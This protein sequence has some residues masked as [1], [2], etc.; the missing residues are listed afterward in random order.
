MC[1]ILIQF[2]HNFNRSHEIVFSLHAYRTRQEAER[3]Q[4]QIENLQSQFIHL[5]AQ[6]KKVADGNAQRKELFDN[7]RPSY[8]TGQKSLLDDDD[9]DEP[10][11][12]F[13]GHAFNSQVPSVEDLRKQQTRIIED[14]NE[15]LD[16]LS[17]VISRQKHLALRIGDEVD[18]QNG[19]I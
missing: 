17:K 4:R 16:A 12:E 6:F 5:Q 19:N 13:G 15:G 10:I 2:E 1:S 14:Q 3:R 18:E 11:A 8:W 9:D 7:G